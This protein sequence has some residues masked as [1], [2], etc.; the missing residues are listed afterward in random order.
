M[1]AAGDTEWACASSAPSE[2]L[3]WIMTTRESSRLIIPV[4]NWSAFTDPP[5][6]SL[7]ET[8]QAIP[9]TDWGS[10]SVEQ[11]G[12]EPIPAENAVYRNS[13]AGGPCVFAD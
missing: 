1:V 6:Q 3:N 13:I 12:F 10:D 7:N 4:L 11:Q 8:R 2:W 5:A 9:I